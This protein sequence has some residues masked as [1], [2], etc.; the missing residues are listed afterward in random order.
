MTITRCDNFVDGAHG[1]GEPHTLVSLL[2][3]LDVFN[4]C[5]DD[6]DGIICRMIP[7]E[8]FKTKGRLFI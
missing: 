5:S 7:Y 2:C 8:C 6:D 4:L 3:A 1:L